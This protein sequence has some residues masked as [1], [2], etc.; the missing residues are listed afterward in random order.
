MKGYVFT[1]TTFLI[2]LAIIAYYSTFTDLA[3][4]RTGIVN[5]QMAGERIWRA[6]LSTASGIP[7]LVNVTY[8]KT[9]GIAEINDTLPAAKNVSYLLERWQAFS[10]QYASD[11]SMTSRFEDLSG[12]GIYLGDNSLSTIRLL[13][14]GVNYTW[15]NWNKNQSTIRVSGSDF[16]NIEHI[17]LNIYVTKSINLTGAI[18]EPSNPSCAGATHCLIINMTV[19]NATHRLVSNKSLDADK[20]NRVKFRLDD[21]NNWVNVTM[22]TLPSLVNV[23][24]SNGITAYTNTKIVLNTASFYTNFMARLNVTSPFGQKI[25][26]VGL[27]IWKSQS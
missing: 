8:V 4:Q 26:P 27:M 16:S 22:G 19:S 20:Q 3:K 2:F 17:E 15:N 6:W 24:P 21:P 9:Y 14:V 11:P 18:W 10:L 25:S 13:P 12:K 1:I 5:E 23:L 7:S